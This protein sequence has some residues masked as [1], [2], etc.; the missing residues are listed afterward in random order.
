MET[1]GWY[2][3]ALLSILSTYFLPRVRRPQ[4]PSPFA[5]PIIGHLY[6]INSSKTPI[7][8]T[9]QALSL[10]HGPIMSLR[11]G[12]SRILLLS[13]ASAVK[14]CFPEHDI[15]FSN[16]PKTVRGDIAG[17]NSTT[18]AW[19]QYGDHWRNL[20]RVT[21]LNIFSPAC[22]R[23]SGLLRDSEVRVTLRQ[24]YNDSNRVQKV[25]VN[26][27]SVI[28]KLALR[29]AGR[30][31]DGI[32]VEN[33]EDYL[34]P[35]VLLNPLD[36]SP[37]LRWIGYGGIEKKLK[38]MYKGKDAYLQGL[39]DNYR[40]KM[41]L[42]SGQGGPDKTIVEALLALQAAEPQVYTD[43]FMKGVIAIMFTAGMDPPVRTMEWAM[44]LLLNHPSVLEKAQ[45]EIDSHVKSGE[46]IEDSDIPKLKYLHCII[47]ETLRLFP[48]APLLLP[49]YSSEDCIISGYKI[50]KNTIVY[51]NTWAIHRDQNVWEDPDE[52]R[53]ERFLSGEAER[54]GYKY[55]PFGI[56][57]RVC[58]G[59]S[60]GLRMIGIILAA[61]IQCF[62]WERVG[63]EL[64]DLSAVGEVTLSMAKPLEAMYS[65]RPSMI[66]FLSQI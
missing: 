40:R 15:T 30:L 39:I 22:I 9:L 48:A 4:P 56:G 43:D 20:R 49:H 35:S 6:L 54:D 11:L 63:S 38:E 37:F 21:A 19:C 52:F 29:H 1:L 47:C 34:K 32:P 31:V 14:A 5:L 55:I 58:P 25:R 36:C 42:D 16:R 28:A 10:K 23:R 26:L 51:I 62:D 33:I 41:E 57:R 53:P 44:A 27:F 66:P 65:P 60:L 46:L 7:Y 12:V 8:R 64:V 2:L 24:L 17:Y 50:P 18:I 59:E 13:S 3:L 61:L 45:N